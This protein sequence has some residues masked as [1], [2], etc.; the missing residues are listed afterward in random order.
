MLA[1][2]RSLGEFGATI[3]FAGNIE[4]ETRTLPLA[5]YTHL[6]VPGG[7]ASALRLV[8]ISIVLSLGSLIFSE[9][10]GRRARAFQGLPS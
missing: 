1:F 8:L 5:I 3:V 2:V 7:D 4:G 10:L 6:Q 9:W